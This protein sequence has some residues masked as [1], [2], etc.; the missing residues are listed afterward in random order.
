MKSDRNEIWH[1]LEHL[2]GDARRAIRWRE[3]YL[4]YYVESHGLMAIR[5]YVA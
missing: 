5:R 3:P 1:W 4:V 2:T